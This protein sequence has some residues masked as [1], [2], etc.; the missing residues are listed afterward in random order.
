VNT[1]PKN[2]IDRTTKTKKTQISKFFS[3]LLD[4]TVTDIGRAKNSCYRAQLM[5]QRGRP[6][7]PDVQLHI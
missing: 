7:S 4:R 1:A 3:K 2:L 5:E 6:L